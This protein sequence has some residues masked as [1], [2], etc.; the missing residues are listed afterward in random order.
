[1][2]VLNAAAPLS[3]EHG[4]EVAGSIYETPEG[5]FRYTFPRIGEAS[6]ASLTTRYRGYHAHPSGEL[7]F[8]NEFTNTGDHDYNWVRTARKDLYLGVVGSKGAVR[9]GVCEYGKCSGSGR[10]GTDPSR[11]LQ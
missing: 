4:L 1:M 6:R 2:H 11:V 9:I 5:L 3:A 8:S 7:V 10:F